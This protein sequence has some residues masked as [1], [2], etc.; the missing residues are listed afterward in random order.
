MTF[1]IRFDDEDE[2]DAPESTPEAKDDKNKAAP[3]PVSTGLFK[4][5]TVLLFGEINQKV[6]QDTVGQLLALAAESDDPIK[7][8]INS[9][10]GHVE[11]GDTVHDIIRFIRPRVLVLGTGW[12]ASAGAHIYLGAARENRFSLPNTRFLIHQPMGGT[13]GQ[14]TDIAIEAREIVKMRQRLNGIIAKETGQPVEKVAADTDRNYWM[15]A[16]EAKAYGIVTS[17][18]ECAD[19]FK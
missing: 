1:P 10:G 9:Q 17:I 3:A 12:V 2:P 18:I 19:D 5:R 6:A 15:S 14:A 7:L 16:E 8:V 13:G 11:S 4:A